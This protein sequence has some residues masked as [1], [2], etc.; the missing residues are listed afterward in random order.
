MAGA[1]LRFAASEI[2]LDAFGWNIEK[3]QSGHRLIATVEAL[4]T[5]HC[6]AAGGDGRFGK[7]QVTIRTDTGDEI[8]AQVGRRCGRTTV[9]IA[10]R[11]PASGQGALY[12]QVASR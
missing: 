10:A 3:P 8:T 1:E 12:P 11:P 2:G 5:S 6:P 9:D 4:P 7:D